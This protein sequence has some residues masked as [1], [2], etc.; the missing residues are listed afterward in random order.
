M[1][2]QSERPVIGIPADS[3]QIDGL[4]F[5]AVGEKYITAVMD[6]AGGWPLV[7]PSLAGR[8]PQQ[9][10][11]DRVDGILL[12]GSHSN[13]EPHR[14][15]GPATEK[16]TRHDPQRDATTLPMIR[17]AIDAGIPVLGICRGFQE[18]NVAFGGSLHQKVHALDGFRDHREPEG[19][20]EEV[21]YGPAHDIQFSAD[22]WLVKLMD[23]ATQANVNSLH[24]QGVD[25]LGEGLITEARAPDGL[26]E[27]F[28]VADAVGFAIA[29]QW[30]PEWRVE[31]NALSAA[32][33]TA[34]GDACR[35]R[36]NKRRCV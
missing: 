7:I 2:I 13:I 20:S 5:Q 27:A 1:N 3:K 14:Y 24:S 31:G 8:I 35:Q 26:I 28:G 15:N 18:M 34:F 6:G 4:V 11:F 19:E 23:G 32:L 22:G 21:Q 33:F 36:A 25:R 9:E 17:N 30:H 12:T 29:V 16:D 10:V